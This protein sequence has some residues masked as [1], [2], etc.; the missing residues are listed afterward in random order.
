MTTTV[1]RTTK[2]ELIDLKPKIDLLLSLWD[3]PLEESQIHS[4]TKIVCERMELI[5]L[6]PQDQILPFQD[7]LDGDFD[8]EYD[9]E[10]EDPY[11]YRTITD[12]M[13]CQ[14][15]DKNRRRMYE[16]WFNWNG[17]YQK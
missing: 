2:R 13:N 8:L 9:A 4:I 17:Y 14:V 15:F 16:V 11:V 10:E 5:G 1:A 3:Y 12:H 7:Y 6:D